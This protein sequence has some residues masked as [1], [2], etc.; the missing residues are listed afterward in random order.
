MK[1]LNLFSDSERSFEK[2]NPRDLIEFFKSS[3]V[4]DSDEIFLT[5]WESEVDKLF[6]AMVIVRIFYSN[7]SEGST[8]VDRFVWRNY[9]AF[10]FSCSSS[11]NKKLRPE[12]QK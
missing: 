6:P 10:D 7:S 4:L 8:V 2:I 9:R 5:N 1:G 12:I 3:H 11:S